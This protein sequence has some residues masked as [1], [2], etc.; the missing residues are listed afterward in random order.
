MARRRGRPGDYLMTD[1][2]YGT[3]TYRSKVTED[4][5]GSYSRRPLQ[6][7]LQ[8][9]SQPLDDPYP[10]PIY[11]GPGYEQTNACDFELQPNYI[12]NT[13]TPFPNTAYTNLFNLNPSIPNMSIGCTFIVAPDPIIGYIVTDEGDPLVTNLGNFIAVT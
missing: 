11:R 1:D 10:V 8:E 12:G 5:W 13:Y 3:T 9:I 2:Y 4:Y 7:N 6:R